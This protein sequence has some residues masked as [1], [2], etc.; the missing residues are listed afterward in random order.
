M[1]THVS[2]AGFWQDGSGPDFTAYCY[3]KLDEIGPSTNPTALYR[4]FDADGALLY[5]GITNQPEERDKAHWRKR[6]RADAVAVL[7]E[8]FPDRG[9]AEVA[10]QC[11]IRHEGPLHNVRVLPGPLQVSAYLYG[12]HIKLHNGRLCGDVTGWGE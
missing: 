9:L 6:W 12:D 8:F 4:Y 11:C 5:V 2:V 10:E 1:N 7:Y 3:Q